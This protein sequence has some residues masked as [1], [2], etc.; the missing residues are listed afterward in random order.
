GEV[1]PRSPY[2]DARLLWGFGWDD[3]HGDTLTLQVNNWGPLRPDQAPGWLGAEAYLAYKSP[4]LCSEWLCGQ[5]VPGVTVP[6]RGGPYAD[7]RL[8][9]TIARTWFVMGGIGHPVHGV[10]EGPLGTPQWRMVYGFGRLDWKPGSIFVTYYDWG[11]D[12][13][14][15]NGVLSAGVNWAF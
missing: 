11:P 5:L 14:A 1:T 15:H 10:F 13:R 6:F 9:F 8:T 2:G 3:W 12:W 7:A 4:Q